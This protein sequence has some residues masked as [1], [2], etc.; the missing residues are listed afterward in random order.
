MDA[1][2]EDMD[3]VADSGTAEEEK[4]YDFRLLGRADTLAVS[5][6]IPLCVKVFDENGL[7]HID[8]VNCLKL[9]LMMA[10]TKEF[11]W[12]V[13]VPIGVR[14][15]I[16]PCNT[17]LWSLEQLVVRFGDGA[18]TTT[19]ILA[20]RVR[21]E[22]SV[23]WKPFGKGKSTL[24]EAA[25]ASREANTRWR[26]KRVDL[27]LG[28]T[29]NV[30]IIK[31][32]VRRWYCD[33]VEMIARV[34]VMCGKF[35]LR[36]SKEIVKEPMPRWHASGGLQIAGCFL[37]KRCDTQGNSALD[38]LLAA[39]GHR[40]AVFWK[41]DNLPL[42]EHFQVVYNRL[43]GSGANNRMIYFRPVTDAFFYYGSSRF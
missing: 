25:T 11:K 10:T 37:S 7:D 29:D 17:I 27:E 35:G 33:D 20:R 34:K 36:P 28:G 5:C 19:K 15:E 18:D 12:I 9:V 31:E 41:T 13:V 16:K 42:R 6:F 23:L 8:L 22:V 43:R 38:K 40:L 39:E 4:C 30:L 1:I 3:L 32:I 21:D 26:Y 14:A 24:S 2:N